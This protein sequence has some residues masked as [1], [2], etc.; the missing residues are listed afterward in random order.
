V[1]E[2]RRPSRRKKRVVP[3]LT[4]ND[5]V[6]RPSFAGIDDYLRELYPQPSQ[7]KV[8]PSAPPLPTQPAAGVEPTIK[9]DK[10][11]TSEDV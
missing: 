10:P 6:S 7:P 11:V 5:I 4:L 2:N 9:A 3:S 8:A 1:A